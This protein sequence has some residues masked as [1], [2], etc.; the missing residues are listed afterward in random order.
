MKN[1]SILI[2]EDSE[3][4]RLTYRH[5]LLANQNFK[6]Q[7]LEAQGLTEGLE[8][9]RTQSPD[10]VLVDINLPDGSGLELLEA[11]TA[12]P[13]DLQS[14]VIVMTG[15]GDEKI[16]VQTLKQ[17]AIDYLVK[18]DITA[19]TLC[20]AIRQGLDEGMFPRKVRQLQQQI[21][22]QNSVLKFK[23]DLFQAIFDNTFQFTGL[24]APDGTAL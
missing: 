18:G 10:L 6:Y 5:Y 7:I 22:I 14:P 2:I 17:G 13:Q 15:Q 16:A 23:D 11:I 21:E 3:S 4:D 12:L 8:L 1:Y 9:W 24:I 19:L 20:R